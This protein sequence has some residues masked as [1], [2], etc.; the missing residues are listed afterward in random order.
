M[1]YNVSPWHFPRFG[2]VR[3][4]GIPQAGSGWA[5]ARASKFGDFAPAGL[6]PGP[7]LWRLLSALRRQ[8]PVGTQRWPSNTVSPSADSDLGPNVAPLLNSFLDNSLPLLSNPP[9]D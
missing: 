3:K 5:I 6:P 7:S 2:L 4:I 8:L 9:C 1:L